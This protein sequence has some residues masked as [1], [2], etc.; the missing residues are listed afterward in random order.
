M[1]RPVLEYQT[2]GA[3]RVVV[4]DF[5]DATLITLRPGRDARA[6]WRWAIAA[7]WLAGVIVFVIHPPGTR[8]PYEAAAMLFVG[9]AVYLPKL[10]NSRPTRRLT[11]V[12]RT[13]IVD[14]V[15]ESGAPRT[16]PNDEPLSIDVWPD[17]LLFTCPGHAPLK[18][19]LTYDR[20]TML[21]VAATIREALDNAA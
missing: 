12:G 11:V 13:L 18:I 15:D 2:R 21:R 3:D 20:A 4:Q 9:G 14:A 17:G 7:V 8:R 6:V 5:G 10:F 1:N 19:P 16:F